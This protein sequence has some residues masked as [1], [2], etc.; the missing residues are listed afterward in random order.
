[1]ILIRF[2]LY[3]DGNRIQFRTNQKARVY[4]NVGTLVY[5]LFCYIRRAIL[6]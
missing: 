3:I 1:M 6:C 5:L 2:I 4:Y